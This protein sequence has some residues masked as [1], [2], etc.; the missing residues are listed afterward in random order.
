MPSAT[1][2]NVFV[3]DIFEMQSRQFHGC[4]RFHE[5]SVNGVYFH[6]KFYEYYNILNRIDRSEM[7]NI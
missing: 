7:Y 2:I 1:F 5:L 4:E 3:L 6:D